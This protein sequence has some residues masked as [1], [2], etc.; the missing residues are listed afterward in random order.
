MSLKNKLRNKRISSPL[1]G[2]IKT[3]IDQDL[4]T[5]PILRTRRILQQEVK[6]YF[7][8]FKVEIMDM[9]VKSMEFKQ[10]KREMTPVKGKDYRDGID[11]KTPLKGKDYKDGKDIDHELV[12]K[13]VLGLV[14]LPKD[15]PTKEEMKEIAEKEVAKVKSPTKVEIKKIAEKVQE[16]FDPSENAKEIA[17]GLEGLRGHEQLD[18]Y[19][20]KNR[21]DI[22]KGDDKGGKRTL[23]RGGQG[24]AVFAFDL[25]S[26]CDGSNKSFTVPIHT[27]ALSLTGSDYPNTYRL[28]TDYTTSG[29]TLTIDA[30]IDAPSDGA[31]LVFLYAK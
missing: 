4:A 27:R 1:S 22:P 6:K 9:L 18:Y 10:I 21:P 3:Q 13:E 19:A 23:H 25:S 20:L 17:L 31:N 14:P 12:V 28:T 26:Q 11:G 30:L 2:K 7:D 16:I 24:L 29:V 8:K 5:S 15:P